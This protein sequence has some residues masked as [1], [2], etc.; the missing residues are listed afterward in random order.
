MFDSIDQLDDF[1]LGRYKLSKKYGDAVFSTVIPP[2]VFDVLMEKGSKGMQIFQMKKDKGT[3]IRKSIS[4]ISEGEGGKFDED[5]YDSM[6]YEY[7]SS[8][9]GTTTAIPKMIGHGD[10]N[11]VPQVVL[12]N[13]FNEIRRDCATGNYGP[14]SKL[15]EE[16]IKAIFGDETPVPIPESEFKSRVQDVLES[17]WKFQADIGNSIHDVLQAYFVGLGEWNGKKMPI[18][19]IGDKNVRRAELKRV[20]RGDDKGRFMTTAYFDNGNNKRMKAQFVD[21]VSTDML[22]DSMVDNLYDIAEKVYDQIKT[23]YGVQSDGKEDFELFAEFPVYDNQLIETREYGSNDI[24]NNKRLSGSIDLMI[25]D[26]NGT[27]HILDWKTSPKSYDMFGSEKRRMY[28]YQLGFYRQMLNRM[29]IDT[30]KTTLG[31]APVRVLGIHKEGD[32]WKIDGIDFRSDVTRIHN[33]TNLS[34]GVMDNIERNLKAAITF[35]PKNENIIESTNKEIKTL[36]PEY[37]Y[38]YENITDKRIQDQF[39]KYCAIN[40][41][42]G[43]WNYYWNE[44]HKGRGRTMGG[45]V[46]EAATEEEMYQKIKEYQI[47]K[48]ERRVERARA[49]RDE[50]VASINNG[51]PSDINMSDASKSYYNKITE[52]YRNGRW[53]VVQGQGTDEALQYGI[54]LL[55][56][57]YTG[58]IDVLNIS[59]EKLD[60]LHPTKTGTT[61]ISGYLHDDIIERSKKSRMLTAIEGNLELIRTLSVLNNLD[62]MFGQDCY[63]GDVLVANVDNAES[64]HAHNEDLKYTYKTLMD[65]HKKDGMVI[66]RSLKIGDS[67]DMIKDDLM[68]YQHVLSAAQARWEAMPESE[69]KK[70]DKP[71]ILTVS[72]DALFWK[73]GDAEAFGSPLEAELKTAS[74]KRNA[75]IRIQKKM[76]SKF[77]FLNEIKPESEV[78]SRYRDIYE[79]YIGISKAI[80]EL[81][82]VQL[83]QQLFESNPWTQFSFSKILTKGY[84]STYMDNPGMMYSDLLNETTGYV[85][86]AYQNIRDRLEDPIARF[87]DIEER[88]VEAMGRNQVT[89]LVKSREHLWDEFYRKNADGSIDEDLVF[90]RPE[91]VVDP[92]KR[93]ILEDLLLEINRARLMTDENIPSDEF[94]LS[95]SNQEKYYYVPIMQ[96]SWAD[97][98]GNVHNASDS[99]LG[100][101]KTGIKSIFS[102]DFWR[103]FVPNMKK[104][105]REFFAITPEE[106]MRSK[107]ESNDLFKMTDTM[108]GETDLET[109]R[110]KIHDIGLHNISMN[111]ANAGL[112]LAFTRVSNFELGNALTLIKCSVL[113]LKYEGD[114]MNHRYLKDIKFLQEYVLKNIKKEDINDKMVSSL[115][116]FTDKL[117]GVATSAVLAFSPVQLIYQPL[118][119]LFTNSSIAAKRVLGDRSFGFKEY[120]QGMKIAYSDLFA[121]K[122]SKLDILNQIFGIN[123]MDMNDYI[124]KA[125]DHKDLATVSGV[126]KF[127]MMFSSRPDYYNRMSIF[128][129]QMIKDGTWDAYE[130]VGN[131]LVYD[132]KKD[133]RFQKLLDPNA[134]KD[135]EYYR[136][137]GEYTAIAKQ[138]MVEGARYQ[139]DDKSGQNRFKKGDRFKYVEGQIMPL[140]KAYTT[141]QSEA[142]KNVADD[143]YGYYSHEKKALI[144]SLVLGKMFMQF[145]TYFS[146][147]KN[148]YLMPGGVR[149]RGEY[150]QATDNEGH[151]IFSYMQDGF[152]RYAIEVDG[153]YLDSAT[154]EEVS[155]ELVVPFYTWRGQYQEG[156]IMTLARIVSEMTHGKSWKEAIE[157]YKNNPNETVRN[158]F[159]TNMR[160]LLSDLIISLLI[161]GVVANAIA[162][163]GDEIADD[164]NSLAFAKDASR[165]LAKSVAN[166]ALDSNIFATFKTMTS[167]WNPMSISWGFQTGKNILGVLS[168]DK[169]VF[170]AFASSVSAVGQMRNSVRSLWSDD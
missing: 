59:N 151:K 45:H 133:G 155:A 17:K 108:V 39:K 57:E 166:A 168:G 149:M 139:E 89:M 163:M 162:N 86:N 123:D 121:K 3:R 25:V 140:P 87:T 61:L 116:K 64:V 78:D 102:G 92:T 169:G 119:G 77:R 130:K 71:N 84:T 34:T 75:L 49:V 42:T 52:K 167:D 137:L 153:R 125:N 117:A 156:A 33:I 100:K 36:L 28:E 112:N 16:N 69:K 1:L 82:G 127:A 21:A 154:Q 23:T 54:I 164:D 115:S 147:K 44:E 65:A 18:R 32:K 43:K 13:Y 124:N 150:A 146:G 53:R 93:K 95:T 56:N 134:V 88:M 148:Q 6:D 22:D 73:A 165:I 131:K 72:R 103:E 104:G 26:K 11:L 47:G 55:K 141:Q 114:L 37:S 144:H 63:F 24:E 27:P 122:R 62:G 48:P 70:H 128:A 106:V 157:I 14:E 15:S 129:A 40:Q 99:L 110:E 161:G 31:I 46:I 105:V 90:V 94:V 132:F 19:L 80:S 79:V 170:D 74:E 142:Y 58:R 135:A 120:S 2:G 85:G 7:V 109:R 152:E 5:P 60:D 29:G 126:R 4:P 97:P 158:A 101:L 107:R 50:L 143:A 160:Q 41:N 12:D 76:E 96:K 38:G 91:E 98:N 118:Q 20:I 81:S 145:K 51:L 111:A 136:Q 9:I 8:F 159:R 66:N 68:E 138:M 113:N 30:S 10:R 35:A 83:K 67:L